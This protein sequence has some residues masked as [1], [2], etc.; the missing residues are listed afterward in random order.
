M[1]VKKLTKDVFNGLV[2]T[3]IKSQKVYGPQV[4][5]E[6][7]DFAPLQSAQDLRLDYDVT[8]QPPKKYLLPAC[9][10]LMTYEVGGA[11][12]GQY[13]DETFTLLGAIWP[14]TVSSIM[15]TGASAQHPTQATR[16]ILNS[17]SGVVSPSLI[18]SFLSKFSRIISLPLT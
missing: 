10:T 2:E 17:L 3:I 16:S 1:T 8:L 7:F 9:E 11:Y 5:G 14:C 12:Q 13:D 15:V 18:S 4:K 6:K